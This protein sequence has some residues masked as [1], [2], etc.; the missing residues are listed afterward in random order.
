MSV[1]FYAVFALILGDAI[2]GAKRDD[3]PIVPPAAQ[4]PP[5]TTERREGCEI[6]DP[7]KYTGPIPSSESPFTAAA[8]KTPP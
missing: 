2:H 8:K 6:T 5:G 4:C 3:A 1:V 7:A